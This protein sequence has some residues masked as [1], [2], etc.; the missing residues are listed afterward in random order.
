MLELITREPGRKLT[1]DLELILRDF[2]LARWSQG[3]P[4]ERR[5]GFRIN[6]AS[7]FLNPRVK[8]RAPFESEVFSASLERA[9]NHPCVSPA[10]E[11]SNGVGVPYFPV[12]IT[13]GHQLWHRDQFI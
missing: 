6:A 3:L 7:C 13:H 10:P 2:T 11:V 4:R 8:A 12:K 5:A 9:R 1:D